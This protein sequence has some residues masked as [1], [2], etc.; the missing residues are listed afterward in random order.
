MVNSH[1][2]NPISGATGVTDWLIK[3]TLSE[4]GHGFGVNPK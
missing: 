2:F 1:S 3:K 4:V